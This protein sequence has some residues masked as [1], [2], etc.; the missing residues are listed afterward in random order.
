MDNYVFW[1]CEAAF[2]LLNEFKAK[3]STVPDALI[4]I[5]VL[6]AFAIQA[7]MDPTNQIHAYILIFDDMGKNTCKSRS[8]GSTLAFLGVDTGG[9]GLCILQ[10]CFLVST[11]R[12]LV[13]D[14]WSGFCRGISPLVGGVNTTYCKCRYLADF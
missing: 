13:V 6:G 7:A 5:S 11:P 3:K 12:L 2:D 8:S 9:P 14:T 1:E 4:L 10:H